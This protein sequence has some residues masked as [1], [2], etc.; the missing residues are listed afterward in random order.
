MEYVLLKNGNVLEITGYTVYQ[1]DVNCGRSRIATVR[2]FKTALARLAEE[3]RNRMERTVK[4]GS[5]VVTHT[6]DKNRDFW[7]DEN[8]MPVEEAAPPTSEPPINPNHKTP[9]AN[10]VMTVSMKHLSNN[11]A[12]IVKSRYQATKFPN[13]ST[14][15]L[16]SGFILSI[17]QIEAST[18]NDLVRI[19][20][21][22]ARNRAQLVFLTDAAAPVSD[23]PLL[24]I[25]ETK[26]VILESVETSL[27]KAL[28]NASLSTH[29]FPAKIEVKFTQET[30]TP[31]SPEKQDRFEIFDIYAWEQFAN[32]WCEF[33]QKNN[34]ATP[35]TVTSITK[36][37]NL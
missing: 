33:C 21:Y 18:P 28:N 12:E 9:T 32:T 30:G 15:K 36:L 31:A 17:N 20:R 22:A 13:A 14:M 34:I 10:T 37:C 23:L 3:N 6:Y 26:P 5:I 2:T 8:K 7:F 35:D 19:L 16:Q 25:D 29:D 27:M 11:T 4:R 1:R 24:A